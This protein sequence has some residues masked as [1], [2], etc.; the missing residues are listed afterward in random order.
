MV[1]TFRNYRKLFNFY[2]HVKKG[3]LVYWFI[4][5]IDVFY[6]AKATTIPSDFVGDAKGDAKEDA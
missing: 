5:F 1:G 4:D 2:S 6:D 3:L